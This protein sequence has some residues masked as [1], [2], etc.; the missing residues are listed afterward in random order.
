MNRKDLWVVFGAAAAALLLLLLSRGGLLRGAGPPP[1]RET[2]AVTLER[3]SDDGGAPVEIAPGSALPAADS[4]LRIT[5]GGSGYSL[6]PL[7]GEYRI[8][9]E[10]PGGE[11]NVIHTGVNSFHMHSS[12]CKNQLCIGQGAVTLDNRD[13]RALYNQVICLPNKVVLELLD[14]TEA[15]AANE[16]TE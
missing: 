1:G 8:T 15:Q 4:Y 13:L 16:A 5:A 6:V 2:L 7:D 9:L 3:L 12:S 10:Q 11:K 14:P